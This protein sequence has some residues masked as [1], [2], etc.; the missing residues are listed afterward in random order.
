MKA[1]LPRLSVRRFSGYHQEILRVSYQIKPIILWESA[2]VSIRNI[3]HRTPLLD[4]GIYSFIAVVW[5][6]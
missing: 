5:K 3:Q 2:P 6:L 4:L 1:L